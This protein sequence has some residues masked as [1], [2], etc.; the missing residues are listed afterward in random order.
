[1]RGTYVTGLTDHDI[2]RLDTFEGSEY[3]KE[4]VKV[5][6]LGEDGEETDENV[7]TTSYVWCSSLKRLH[8]EEWDYDEFRKMAL[9][10]WAD[11]SEEYECIEEE[12]EGMFLEQFNE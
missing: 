7:M 3:S 4:K 6:L 5:V 8:E 11:N 12:E 1:M 9:H 2:G 10:R